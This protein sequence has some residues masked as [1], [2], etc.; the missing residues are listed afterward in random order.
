MHF[1]GYLRRMCGLWNGKHR[2]LDGYTSRKGNNKNRHDHG[3]LVMLDG[4]QSA[5]H[6]HVD[7]RRF[8]VDSLRFQYIR[9]QAYRDGRALW[10]HH[11]LE[12]L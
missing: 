6:K 7:V 1:P 3:A 5:P 2:N 8:D 4:A 12:E 11:L 10:Q 9:W